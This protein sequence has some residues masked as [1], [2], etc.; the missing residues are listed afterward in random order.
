MVDCEPDMD[1]FELLL[2]K[3]I[4]NAEPLT[5]EGMLAAIKKSDRY[6]LKMT[7]LIHTMSMAHT[8]APPTAYETMI[9]LQRFRTQ[10]G[11]ST[12][13]L[14]ADIKAG[15]PKMPVPGESAPNT[16]T[17]NVTF[18]EAFELVF[19]R[20]MYVQEY[21]RHSASPPTD[22]NKLLQAHNASF[23][24]IAQLYWDF[25][26][27]R[28][29]EHQY[30]RAHFFNVEDSSYYDTLF[31]K[32]LNSST[33]EELMKARIHALY[34]QQ[35]A[36]VLDD[37][38]L[39]YVFGNVKTRAITLSDEKLHDVLVDFKDETDGIIKRIMSI[40]SSTYTRVPDKSEL[41]HAAATYRRAVHSLS[42]LEMV[43]AELE[44]ELMNRLEFHDVLKSRIRARKEN[45]TVTEVYRALSRLLDKLATTDMK[46]LDEAID[47]ALAIA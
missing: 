1:L 20:P 27:E 37:A 2:N 11:Y 21:V 29:T 28:I 26:A 42:P 24:Q 47:G 19:K 40:Y 25:R 34:D 12:M 32:A 7:E 31:G 3:S 17:Y 30:M 6:E 8:G 13:G 33:Y 46:A 36:E 35:Y 4:D 22:L 9:Y 39:A 16:P 18:V 45:I 5:K 23:K 43:D 38:D 14:E 41:V 15:G 10:D 44:R